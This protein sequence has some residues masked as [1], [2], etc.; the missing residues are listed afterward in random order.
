MVDKITFM[1]TLH[2][3]QDIMKASASPMTK[4][5][6]QGYFKDMDLSKEQ[7]EM[8]YQFLQMPQEKS[9][10]NVHEWEGEE[11]ADTKKKSGAGSSSRVNSSSQTKGKP[12]QKPQNPHFQMYLKEISAIPALTGE[13]QNLLYQRLLA[14]EEAAMGEISHQWLK[15]VIKIA[16]EYVTPRV[17][18]EDLV[19]EGNISLLLG[20]GQISGKAA[21]YGMDEA[22]SL[23]HAQQNRLE[24]RLEEFVREGMEQYRQQL[25]GEAD[26]ENT[27]LAKVSLLHEARKAL[28]EENGTDPTVRELCEYT[29]LSPQ[30]IA[31][32]LDLHEKARQS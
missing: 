9:M 30:E 6:I 19:Q 32:I 25:E 18:L 11:T 31:D 20:L 27:I 23:E 12:A 8:I 26:S 2:S 24:R 10:G 1:E 5:E 29:R 28:A 4:E 22:E 15:K 16:R 21:E 17:F 13:Q 14:G 7:Q 3:V